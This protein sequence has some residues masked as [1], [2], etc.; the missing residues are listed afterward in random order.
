MAEDDQDQDSKT[1]DP[2]QKKLE[3]AIE[4]G[5]V[6]TSREVN[7]FFMLFFVTLLVIWVFPTSFNFTALSLRFFIE[8]AGNI[9]IDQGIVNILLAKIFGKILLYL[10]PI[11]LIVVIVAIFSSYVQHGEFIFT[12][13]QLQPKLS[14]ISIVEGFKRIFSKKSL[15]EFTKSFLKVSLVSFF[16]YLIIMGDVKDLNQYQ[17]LTVFGILSHLHSM[18]NHIMICACIIMVIIASLD[19]FYQRFEHYQSL[20]MTKYEQKE[21]YKQLEGSPEIKKKIRS[22]RRDQAQRRI[23]QTVPKATVIITNPEHYAVALAY[24][25]NSSA[26]PILV[27][28]GLDL[29]AQKI[30]EIAEENRI[31]IVE[32]PPLARAIYKEVNIN[33]EIPV[34]HYQAVAKIISYVMSMK[35]PKTNF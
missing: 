15:V 20:K 30:K 27:A 23:K 8:Q 21:E 24:D 10:S 14:R 5:Q 19:Y 31:P 34:A 1:E 25:H 3:D 22:L 32:N 13:E 28:K 9:T 33:Q 17:D 35:R 26:A 29:I 2:S 4:K 7:S 16:I 11:L 6:V 18:I 12:A